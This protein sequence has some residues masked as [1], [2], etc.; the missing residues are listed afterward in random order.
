MPPPVALKEVPLPISV[1]LDVAVAAAG[2]P[3]RLPPTTMRPVFSTPPMLTLLAVRDGPLS[4]VLL[5]P[6][7]VMEPPSAC[8]E[9]PV[10]SVF[11]E[12][13]T[14]IEPP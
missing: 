12:P 9:P 2:L 10:N 1:L 8:N 5:L 14:E 7:M 13:L 6:E 4:F 11:E 3:L